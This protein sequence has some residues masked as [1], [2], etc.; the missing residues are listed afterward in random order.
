[1][2]SGGQG[3][4]SMAK[5]NVAALFIDSV[6]SETLEVTADVPNWSKF[7]YCTHHGR[8]S[9]VCRLSGMCS[10]G[11]SGAMVDRHGMRHD[12]DI[13]AWE[14]RRSATRPWCA[15]TVS[16]T[17]PFYMPFFRHVDEVAYIRRLYEL[18]QMYRERS[19][20]EESFA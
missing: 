10:D 1:M 9:D 5:E 8:M 13:G 7:E 2:H 19:T 18:F 4:C 11:Q 20:E 14:R 3:Y 15:R 12:T 17:G 16:P 6:L